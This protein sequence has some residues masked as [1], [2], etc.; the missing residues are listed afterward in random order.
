[1]KSL[2]V[3]FSVWLFCKTWVEI[4]VA[5]IYVTCRMQITP[6]GVIGTPSRTSFQ[7]LAAIRRDNFDW[8]HVYATFPFLH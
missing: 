1:M 3:Y 6:L 7:G 5:K 4:N 2:D 8:S